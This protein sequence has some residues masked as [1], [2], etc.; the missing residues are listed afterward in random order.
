MYLI[1]VYTFLN[2]GLMSILVMWM[3]TQLFT[4]PVGEET[5]TLLKYFLRTKLTEMH[6]KLSSADVIKQF[7]VK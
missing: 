4:M 3:D 1:R 5:T 6:S 7:F 2:S